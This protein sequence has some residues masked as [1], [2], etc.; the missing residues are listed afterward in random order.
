M[1]EEKTDKYR[2]G[3]LI[4]SVSLIV[5]ILSG[6]EIEKISATTGTIKLHRPWVADI[7]A[8]LIY[9]YFLW[10]SRSLFIGNHVR[11]EF[12]TSLVRNAD[13]F[14]FIKKSV[15]SAEPTSNPS[16]SAQRQHLMRYEVLK[17]SYKRKL[18][19]R[20]MTAHDIHLP[21]LWI[22]RIEFKTLI[23]NFYTK[24]AFREYLFPLIVAITTLML[25]VLKYCFKVL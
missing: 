1:T 25:G 7:F 20:E 12:L 18:F 23:T 3:L 14:K 4:I 17:D 22:M 5:Y 11:D 24:E 19:K 21:Y 10:C 2:R 6:G 13:F 9:S 16:V 15:E 8:W